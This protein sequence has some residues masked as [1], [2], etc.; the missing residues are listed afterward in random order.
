MKKALF[1]KIRES[2]VSV[3]PVA[4]IVLILS[5]TPVADFSVKEKIVFSVS[6]PFLMLGI[7]LFNL[8]ADM[9]MT[10]MGERIGEGLTKSKK[11]GILLSVGFLM[12]AL[13]TV[14]EPDL[15]VL[16]AQVNKVI[17]GTALI[18]TVGTGVGFF[19][20]IGILKIVFKKDLSSIL[21][22]FYMILFSN[23]GKTITQ[24]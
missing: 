20:F 15:S 7:S 19:L 3:I 9:A 8:G 1:L 11:L 12:G 23:K 4:A 24:F 10:P 17:N 5:F 6:V 14:A 2:L 13:I 16:A 21:L 22:F 18:L